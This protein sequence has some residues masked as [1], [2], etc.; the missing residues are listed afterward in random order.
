MK[1]K[2][3]FTKTKMKLVLLKFALY[4]F[5]GKFI[6]YFKNKFMGTEYDVQDLLLKR[7]NDY[8]RMEYQISP[9]TIT[10]GLVT[11]PK[12]ENFDKSPYII[13][14]D[15]KYK[16]KIFHLKISHLRTTYDVDYEITFMQNINYG[17]ELMEIT[18]FYN[19][20]KE[21]N[22]ALRGIISHTT[23]ES[24]DNPNTKNT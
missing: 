20:I 12:V 13:N 3:F 16:D 22:Q 2:R 4:K 8:L 9:F 1:I 19:L 23:F 21:D 5:L 17:S 11:L 14:F 15:I 7:L 24:I 18:K 6:P 10:K